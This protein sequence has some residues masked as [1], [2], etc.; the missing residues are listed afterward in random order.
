LGIELF[1]AAQALDLRRPTQT[2]KKLELLFSEY[3]KSVP[4]LEKD[5][6][7]SAH[8]KASADFLKELDPDQFM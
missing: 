5:E 8:M 1:T 2:S 3:R 7:M 4:F 6:V